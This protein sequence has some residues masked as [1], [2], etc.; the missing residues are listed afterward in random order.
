MVGIGVNEETIPTIDMLTNI[1][2]QDTCHSETL[3]NYSV[4]YF[5]HDKLTAFQSDCTKNKS[6]TFRCFNKGHEMI[7]C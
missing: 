6:L 1:L 2:L 4:T 5:N 7:I 3:E